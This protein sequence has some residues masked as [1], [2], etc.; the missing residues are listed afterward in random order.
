M[1]EHTEDFL[2]FYSHSWIRLSYIYFCN[3]AV[4]GYSFGLAEELL[5]PV[6]FIR[7]CWLLLLMLGLAGHICLCTQ[8]VIPLFHSIELAGSTFQ[9]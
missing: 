8:Y 6:T 2:A 9:K 3:F 5:F 7:K 4:T 1:E